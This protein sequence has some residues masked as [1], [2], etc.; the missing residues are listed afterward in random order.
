VSTKV[1][2][3]RQKSFK[4]VIKDIERYLATEKKGQVISMSPDTNVAVLELQRSLENEKL[5]AIF[6][7][8]R[9]PVS[10][11]A[12]DKNAWQVA[13]DVIGVVRSQA[14]Q[15]IPKQFGE[16]IPKSVHCAELRTRIRDFLRR[17]AEAEK[18]PA[19][20]EELAEDFSRLL[21]TLREYDGSAE[22]GVEL[23]LTGAQLV[24][25]LTSSRS[26]WGLFAQLNVLVM[27]K[28]LIE[29]EEYINEMERLASEAD[30]VRADPWTK[31]CIYWLNRLPKDRRLP[32]PGRFRSYVMTNN[33][34]RRLDGLITGKLQDVAGQLAAVQRLLNELRMSKDGFEL[35]GMTELLFQC[36]RAKLL[37]G[38]QHAEA[39][40]WLIDLGKDEA[41][42]LLLKVRDYEDSATLVSL[43]KSF[44]LAAY[45]DFRSFASPDDASGED[46]NNDADSEAA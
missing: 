13:T 32:G 4:K 20:A 27:A 10:G 5:K 23:V 18:M 31:K 2:I 45:P 29:P 14:S 42:D 17:V 8:E 26:I 15:Y 28:P 34:T 9:G 24:I 40:R 37:G 43:V 12:D 3:P 19:N 41:E 33:A 46:E 36:V 22:H 11:L 30:I 39:I 7:Q 16:G 35:N 25:D 6:R 44:M 1:P 38:S 21:K